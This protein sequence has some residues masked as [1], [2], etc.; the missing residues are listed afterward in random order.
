MNV[1]GFHTSQSCE[2]HIN[3]GVPTPWVAIES[4]SKPKE[5]FIKAKEIFQSVAQAYKISLDQIKGADNMDAYWEA[6][7]KCKQNGETNCFKEW[8][9]K[10]KKLQRKMKLLLDEFYENRSVEE[11]TKIIIEENIES[12][13]DIR[14]N[15][16]NGEYDTFVKCHNQEMTEKEKERFALELERYRAE[17][18]KFTKFLEK[19]YFKE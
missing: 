10:N 2:G 7:R 14:C 12:D 15:M 13:F 11:N 8:R 1:L 17:M 4:L 9:E 18:D 3:G 6:I 16:N 19:K 5:R